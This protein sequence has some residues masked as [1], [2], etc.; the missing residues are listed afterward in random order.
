MISSKMKRSIVFCCVCLGCFI[1]QASYAQSASSKSASSLR[2]TLTLGDPV[3]AAD[4]LAPSA[5]S[6]AS[7]Q[8]Q[9]SRS[10]DANLAMSIKNSK[11]LNNPVYSKRAITVSEDSIVV[12]LLGANG[13]ILF[14]DVK[15]DPRVIRDELPDAG[16]GA[17]LVSRKLFRNNT[18]FLIDVPEMAGANTLQILKPILTDAGFVLSLLSSVDMN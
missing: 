18:A 11:K 14:E 1:S 7:D 16:V 3:A 4:V 13:A 9:L 10:P 2:L 5:D 8:A 15:P 12:R 17:G 6:D